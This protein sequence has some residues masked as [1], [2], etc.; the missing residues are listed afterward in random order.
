[1]T[2]QTLPSGLGAHLMSGLEAEYGGAATLDRAHEFVSES[3]SGEKTTVNSR[4]IRKNRMVAASSRRVVTTMGGS[5][6]IELEIAT[7]GMGRLFKA[8]LGEGESAQVASTIAYLQTFKLGAFLPSLSFQVVRPTAENPTVEV[9]MT[10]LG[11]IVT[12]WELGISPDQAL[13]LSLDLD[14][15]E[16]KDDITAGTP[17][18]VPADLFH[19]AQGAIKKDGSELAE[20]LSGNVRGSNALKTGRHFLGGG[21]KKALPLREGFAELTGALEIE[22]TAANKAAIYDAYKSNTPCELEFV[23]TGGE[24]VAG[25]NFGLTVTLSEVFFNGGAPTVGG[26]DVLTASVD[27]EAQDDGT[28]EPILIELKTTDTAI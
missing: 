28:N 12:A 11:S 2:T 9:P 15:R 21:G 4:A 13:S 23:F 17:T 22:W 3:L 25:H 14:V 1:M 10:Y 19:Y 20:I 8:A 18:Y 26:P 7:K 27:F 16:E 6:S 5:G 24:I